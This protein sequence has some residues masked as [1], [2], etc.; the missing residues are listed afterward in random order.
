M[1]NMEKKAG[2]LKVRGHTKLLLLL[3]S[4]PN[5]ITMEIFKKCDVVRSGDAF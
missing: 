3:I 2:A 5:Y 4:Y 1:E